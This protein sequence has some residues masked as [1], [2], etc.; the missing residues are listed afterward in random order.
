[1]KKFIFTLTALLAIATGSILGTHQVSAA[2]SSGCDDYAIM[3]CGAAD[4][5][6]FIAKANQDQPGDLKAIYANFGLA[7]SDYSRF[8]NTA[9]HG[10][11]Y[12]DGRIVVD[13]VVVGHSTLNISRVHDSSFSQPVTI[14]GKTYWGGSFGSTYHANTASVLV[15][16]NDRGVMQFAAIDS[17]GNPQRITAEHPSYSCDLLQ[18]NKVSGQDNSYTFTTKASAA[19]GAQVVKAVYDFGDGTSQ[20]VSDLSQPVLHH[21]SK[22]A[23]VRVTVT[24]K[25]PGGGTQTV[26]SADCATR[27]TVATTPPPPQPN[28]YAQCLNLTADKLDTYMYRFTAKARFGNGA[29]FTSADMNFGDNTAVVTGL[30]AH[31]DMVTVKHTYAKVGTYTATATLHFTTAQGK[32]GTST[33]QVSITPTEVVHYC[34]PGVKEGSPDCSP[35][36]LVNAGP[37]TIVATVF[38]GVSAVAGVAHFVIRKRLLGL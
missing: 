18:K 3:R 1:M 29:K 5:A 27:I 28:P 38:G 31:G 35:K 25:L 16:F 12:N 34:K 30:K 8:R 23:T 9:Q 19:H 13:G 37:G 10:T 6:G 32:A 2:S 24:V 14:N 17:C 20:T 7:P 26:T 15:M 33:C 36:Q 21:F 4:A 22:S 11:L